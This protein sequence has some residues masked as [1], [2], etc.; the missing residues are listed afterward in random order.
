M[1][2]LNLILQIIGII[3]VISLLTYI[4]CGTIMSLKEDFIEW[5]YQKAIQEK[6]KY[7]E[8][9]KAAKNGK[10]IPKK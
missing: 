8:D 3:L 1:E 4:I 9:L 2:T 5:R 7:H 10:L 6:L